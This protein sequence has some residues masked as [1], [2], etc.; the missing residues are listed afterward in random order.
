MQDNEL[1]ENPPDARGAHDNQ[2]LPGS[3]L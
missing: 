2:F 1:L 3:G